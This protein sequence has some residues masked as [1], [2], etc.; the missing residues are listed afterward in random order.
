MIDYE[1][2]AKII[3]AGSVGLA[4]VAIGLQQLIKRWKTTDAETSILSMLHSELE[5][6]SVQNTILSEHI[7]KMQ[8][9]ANNINLQLGKLQLENQKLHAEVVC[10]TKEVVKLRSAL[11]PNNIRE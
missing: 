7:H 10:L 8:L 2:I 5:R 3:G 11:P 6:M 1:S 9:E 4:G